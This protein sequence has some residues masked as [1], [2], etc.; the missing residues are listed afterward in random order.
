MSLK[1]RIREARSKRWDSSLGKLTKPQLDAYMRACNLS[2]R[3]GAMIMPAMWDGWKHIALAG[4]MPRFRFQ[5]LVDV[6]LRTW[7]ELLQSLDADDLVAQ[8]GGSGVP[9]P[10]SLSAMSGTGLHEVRLL[11]CN[12]HHTWN[13]SSCI[14]G[15]E[16]HPKGGLAVTLIESHQCLASRVKRKAVWGSSTMFSYLAEYTRIPP[17]PSSASLQRTFMSSS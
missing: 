14:S 4:G 11:Q 6:A 5:A 10:D 15:L 7:V 2:E 16:L 3:Y 9:C 17:S 12:P 8:T 1:D 13:A